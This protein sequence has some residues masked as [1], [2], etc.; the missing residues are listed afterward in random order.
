[1]GFW[2]TTTARF[3]EAPRVVCCGFSSGLFD[4]G[5]RIADI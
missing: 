3:A 1:M 4:R 5:G 2:Q